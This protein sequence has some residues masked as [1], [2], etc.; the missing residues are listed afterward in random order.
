MNNKKK[1][2]ICLGLGFLLTI[3]TAIVPG[4][5]LLTKIVPVTITESMSTEVLPVSDAPV[6]GVP[7]LHV[8]L[9][10]L[11]AAQSFGDYE[12]TAYG[13]PFRMYERA[14]YR[15][16]CGQKEAPTAQVF[17]LALVVN[18]LFWAGVVYGG[19][20]LFMRSRNRPVRVSATK[21]VPSQKIANPRIKQGSLRA[22]YVL[23]GGI[24]GLAFCLLFAL[25]VS[26]LVQY[27]TDSFR[28]SVGAGNILS[29]LMQDTYTWMLLACAGLLAALLVF[30]NR[31]KVTK[32]A[33]L[34]I[35]IPIGVVMI[36]EIPALISGVSRTQLAS[37]PY[38]LA[39]TTAVLVG[40]GWSFLVYT[41]WAVVMIILV[42]KGLVSRK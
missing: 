12:I 39:S 22:A 27:R 8:A 17:P 1:L 14:Q 23:F 9:P 2:L 41:I 10:G 20:W 3:L 11:C 7:Q 16:A 42:I 4:S 5:D 19:T 33:T 30:R 40:W 38:D 34:S 35:L 18:L 37:G 24:L 26:Q 29:G 6:D 13:V 32:S 36:I 15:D 31:F 21:M 28:G 25:V